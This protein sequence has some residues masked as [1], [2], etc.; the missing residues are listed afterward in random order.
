MSPPVN[1]RLPLF[2]VSN[3]KAPNF[4]AK[5]SFQFPRLRASY[6]TSQPKGLGLYIKCV[7]LS[8]Y[9][10]WCF[11]VRTCCSKYFCSVKSSGPMFWECR[12]CENV[13]VCLAACLHILSLCGSSEARVG[14][15]RASHQNTLLV[16]IQLIYII[17]PP[18]W[19]TSPCPDI[20]LMSSLCCLFNF[21]SWHHIT[22]FF[23]LDRWAWGPTHCLA[24]WK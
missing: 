11:V 16:L 6:T 3:S 21:L 10:S 22:L 7:I 24:H 19:E 17:L 14:V 18:S 12:G 13:E 5:D 23:L 9:T 2:Q 1:G 8:F 4:T 15:L 20:T